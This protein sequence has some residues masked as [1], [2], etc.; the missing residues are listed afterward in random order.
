MK[1]ISKG[2]RSCGVFFLPRNTPRRRTLFRQ[3]FDFIT[4]LADIP[5]ASSNLEQHRYA[6]SLNRYPKP[7]KVIDAVIIGFHPASE[8]NETSTLN[9]WRTETT[10]NPSSHNR[11]VRKRSTTYF[12]TK[13]NQTKPTLATMADDDEDIAALVIDNGS[14]MCKGTSQ[15]R[16]VLAL[17]DTT[18]LMGRSSWII[19]QNDCAATT[20]A[21]ASLLWWCTCLQEDSLTAALEA[22]RWMGPTARNSGVVSF[23]FTHTRDI[24]LAIICILLLPNLS[25]TLTELRPLRRRHTSFWNQDERDW[26][27]TDSFRCCCNVL[28]ALGT[29]RLAYD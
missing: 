6:S 18:L 28:S 24:L 8:R 23:G 12:F 29:S 2:L 27:H 11:V 10:H 19:G 3:V 5:V 22:L 25:S 21:P 4:E 13:A 16:F 17:F 7:R 9:A 14:G 1:V 20:A 15:G 26:Q